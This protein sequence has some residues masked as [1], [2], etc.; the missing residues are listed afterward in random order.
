[1]YEIFI[2]NKGNIMNKE[3]QTPA[4]VLQ[5]LMDKYQLNA[6]SLSTAI[7]LSYTA[8]RQIIIGKT[9]VSVPTAM[10]LSKLFGQTP[11]FWLDLQRETDIAEAGNDKELQAVLKGISKVKE[12]A[13]SK[14]KASKKHGKKETLSD[15]RKKAAKVPGAKGVRGKTLKP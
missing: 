15:K 6:F 5:S 14:A 7:S 11:A 1:V 9:K 10:R 13:A 4:S 2:M 3:T 8:V 12:P